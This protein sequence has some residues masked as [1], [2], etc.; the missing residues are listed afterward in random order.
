MIKC[1]CPECQEICRIYGSGT[2][3]VNK[4]SND[5]VAYYFSKCEKHGE[6]TVTERRTV[7][8]PVPLGKTERK[9][10]NYTW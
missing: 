4:N 9:I 5:I 1:R 2:M 10:R 3:R 6:F 7:N 8:I